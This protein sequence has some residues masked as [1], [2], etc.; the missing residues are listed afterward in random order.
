MSATRTLYTVTAAGLAGILLASCALGP[1]FER[2]QAPT[3]DYSTRP[4][5]AQTASVKGAGGAAQRFVPGESVAGEWW[6]LFQSPVLNAL[7]EEALAHNPSL[8]AAE[9]SLRQA[10]AIY[11]A[12]RDAFFPYIQGDANFNRAQSYQGFQGPGVSRS[13]Y[14]VATAQVSVSY[15]PDIFGATHRTVEGFGA[16]RDNA[17]FQKEAAFLALTSNVVLTAIEDASLSA[18][19]A[20]TADIL[21]AQD[22][23]LGVLRKQLEL[24]GIPEVQVL[25]QLTVVA[26][27]R[28][29]LAPLQ[30]A[31][32]ATRH[33]LLALVGR[34]PSED[35]GEVID[36]AQLTLPRDLPVSLPSILVAQRPDIRA[37]EASL[38]AASADIGVA[39]ANIFPR[40]TLNASYGSSAGALEE[41]FTAGTG[42]WS[43]GAGLLQPI[44]RGGELFHRR[45]A[46]IA[47]FDAAAAQYRGTV[48]GAFQNVADVLRALEL[49]AAALVA[50]VD[51]EAAARENFEIARL[52]LE[53]GGTSFLSF[54]DAQRNYQQAR[55]ALV[56]AQASRFSDTAALFVAL[57]GGWEERERESVDA[58]TTRVE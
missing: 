16:R 52:Q 30:K 46:V 51:A 33:R 55:I 48:L 12:E 17:R 38:H 36:L 32:S 28:A 26:Q 43:I 18:Q 6:T 10:E 44:W 11:R 41:L 15:S 29:T 42:V 4:L 14:S 1:D 13:P 3:A 54:L 58:R 53:T 50:Q 34:F 20:A 9:A 21:A 49:D 56:Q 2:P 45:R 24:G 31:Q 19:V 5:P 39:T 35:K 7:V 27:T 22:Q 8:E 25:Q 47:A 37:A 23:Q 40:L 57:G